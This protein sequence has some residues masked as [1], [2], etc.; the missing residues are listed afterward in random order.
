MLK[1]NHPI[2]YRAPVIVLKISHI[3]KID[4]FTFIFNICDPRRFYIIYYSK[5][6]KWIVDFFYSFLR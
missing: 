6:E 5:L 3:D 1:Q 2:L 4:Y